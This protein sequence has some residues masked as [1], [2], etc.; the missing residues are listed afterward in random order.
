MEDDGSASSPADFIDAASAR[1]RELMLTRDCRWAIIRETEDKAQAAYRES[2][3]A[4]ERRRAAEERRDAAI[5]R[6]QT[7]SALAEQ[8]KAQQWADEDEVMRLKREVRRVV[9]ESREQ[10]SESGR[11][12]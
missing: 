7:L 5:A 4:E 9:D 11:E 3:D 8:F 6:H 10:A 12:P 2:V 1:L